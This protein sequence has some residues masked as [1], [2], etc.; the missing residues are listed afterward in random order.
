MNLE[1]WYANNLRDFMR[2][3]ANWIGMHSQLKCKNYIRHFY[4]ANTQCTREAFKTVSSTLFCY[5]KRFN[6]IFHS[7]Q[8][9]VD[10]PILWRLGEWAYKFPSIAVRKSVILYWIKDFSYGYW[11]FVVVIS[12]K[13][14]SYL[15]FPL[16]NISR[17]KKNLIVY[18]DYVFKT[19]GSKLKV[20]PIRC[21]SNHFCRP[22]QSSKCSLGTHKKGQTF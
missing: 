14:A 5:S 16:S 13:Q 8:P 21:R 10:F 17:P 2:N 18:F 11:N 1:K 15:Q 20:P 22:K 19:I 12:L 4:Y 9:N 7:R 3:F 6:F